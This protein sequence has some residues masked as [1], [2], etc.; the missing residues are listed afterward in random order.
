MAQDN[1]TSKDAKQAWRFN[2]CHEA[3]KGNLKRVSMELG[4]KNAML[5][6]DDADVETFQRTARD[7]G[8][9]QQVV[10]HFA[11]T[12]G[13]FFDDLQAVLHHGAVPAGVFAAQGADI[14][15]DQ[16]DRGL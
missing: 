9:V 5:V 2:R 10:D 12:V 1:T 4:G 11:E 7:A 15:F 13:F 3:S 14:A 6:L 16:C 8:Q